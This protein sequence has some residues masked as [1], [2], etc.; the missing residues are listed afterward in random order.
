MAIPAQFLP[1]Y[2]IDKEIDLTQ[3]DQVVISFIRLLLINSDNLLFLLCAV[4]LYLSQWRR[5][6]LRTTKISETSSVGHSLTH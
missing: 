1:G 5:L 4:D 2:S 6:N 3:M